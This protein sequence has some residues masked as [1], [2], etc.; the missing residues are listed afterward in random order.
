MHTC[1]RKC[2]VHYCL[3]Y[4][5]IYAVT[6]TCGNIK[7]TDIELVRIQQSSNS[8]TDELEETMTT[9]HCAES[10]SMDQTIS[11]ICSSDRV[12]RWNVD[13]SSHGCIGNNTETE[14]KLW[15]VDMYNHIQH[16]LH[17]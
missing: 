16:D 4:T 8:T 7:L 3:A 13:P 17:G 10:I 11:M 6:I 9:Y 2:D 14:S 1:F 15:K 12:S 5:F